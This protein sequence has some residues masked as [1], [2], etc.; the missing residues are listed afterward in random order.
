MATQKLFSHLAIL[1]LCG[2]ASA[3]SLYRTNRIEFARAGPDHDAYILFVVAPSTIVSSAR[4][5][6]GWLQIESPEDPKIFGWVRKSDLSSLAPD[7]VEIVDNVG[8]QNI[9]QSG[10]SSGTKITQSRP[11]KAATPRPNPY[12]MVILTVMVMLSTVRVMYVV[13]RKEDSKINNLNSLPN[14]MG[15]EVDNHG[16]IPHSEINRL[17]LSYDDFLQQHRRVIVNVSPDDIMCST[18]LDDTFALMGEF[19]EM[20][21]KL[22]KQQEHLYEKINL[23]EQK[24]K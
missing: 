2:Y 14:V 22:A 10:D 9:P 12:L 20:V 4:E 3:T 6:N 21:R 15:A 16:K 5:E 11:D 17:L 23:L 7:K 8:R 18:H 24:R 13:T 19:A 1:L